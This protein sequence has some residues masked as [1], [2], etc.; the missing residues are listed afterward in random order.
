MPRDHPRT[1]GE[2]Q[3]GVPGIGRK[4]GSPPRMRGKECGSCFG[5]GAVG[6]TPAH[7][8][9]RFLHFSPPAGW[10][11]HPRAC[12]EK[13]LRQARKRH[14]TGSPPRMRGKVRL[15]PSLSSME[16][17]TPAHAGKRRSLPSIN[18]RSRDHPRACGEKKSGA[19]S[20]GGSSGSPPRMRGKACVPGPPQARTRITPAHAG[21]SLHAPGGTAL[22]G[23]HPRACGEKDSTAEDPCSEPGSP[24]RMRGKGRIKIIRPNQIRITPAHAGKSTGAF[25]ALKIIQDHPRACGEKQIQQSDNT[26]FLG[27]PPRMR[28]KVHHSGGFCFVQG[29][30][31][32]HAGK[33]KTVPRA[34]QIC[35]DHPRACGEKI[36]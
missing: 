36:C 7:A 29:I 2:K 28:G 1:C 14:R 20:A 30:T 16:R 35:G 31:P 10:G 6:I 25:Q 18:S 11:D 21:K 8:G 5:C 24:P 33:S 3:S 26:S 19:K 17:I 12:G 13:T 27:S 15:Y 32:A 34:I 4:E 23:D 9:K 22:G